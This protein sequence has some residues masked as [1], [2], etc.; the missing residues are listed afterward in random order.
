MMF[1]SSKC[2][3]KLERAFTVKVSCKHQ[4]FDIAIDMEEL[5]HKPFIRE[6]SKS[7]KTS[8]DSISS[9]PKTVSRNLKGAYVIAIND[10]AIFSETNVIDA[11]AAIRKSKDKSF[12]LIVG[13]LDKISTPEQQRELDELLLHT[14]NFSA[15]SSEDPQDDNEDIA[16]PTTTMGPIAL[17]P[18]HEHNI[19]TPT[20]GT[21]RSPR[22]VEKEN[23]TIQSLVIKPHLLSDIDPFDHLLDNHD[24]IPELLSDPEVISVIQH[25]LMAIA[26]AVPK[27]E[28][29]ER[30]HNRTRP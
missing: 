14:S 15:D 12:R 2:P 10:M 26:D 20:P 21:R 18:T 1:Y 4:T 9:S 16:T 28:H 24:H 22:L 30:Y 17:S 27:Y 6:M 7:K 23:T 13:H 19:S 25:H 5:F 3:F 11:L 29:H 8:I